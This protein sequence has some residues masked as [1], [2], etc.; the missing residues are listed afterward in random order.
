MA[1]EIGRIYKMQVTN[2]LN[3]LHNKNHETD[4][5]GCKSLETP[6]MFSSVHKYALSRNAN[7]ILVNG[8]DNSNFNKAEDLRTKDTSQGRAFV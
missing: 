1:C 3:V 8:S 2:P 6:R 4:R 5:Q 7:E